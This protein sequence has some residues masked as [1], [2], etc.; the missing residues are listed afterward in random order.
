MTKNSKIRSLLGASVLAVS[1]A[2][3]APANAGVIQLGFIIDSSG[4]IGSTDF[5]VITSG[6]SSA[7]NN[8]IPVG[9]TDTYEVSVVRF[10]STA[11]AVISNVLVTDATARSNLATDIANIAY[12]GGGTNFAAAFSAMEGVLNNTIGDA[13]NIASYVNFSTDGQASLATTEFNSLIGI[14]VDNVS[15]EGIGGNIDVT[16]LTTNYCYPGPCDTTSPY[17]FPTQGFYIG[18]ADAQGYASAIGTKIGIVTGVTV[19]EPATI[20]M[21]GL[22][23]A[24]FAGLRR[25]KN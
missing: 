10:A 19:P 3:V 25:R 21:L 17:N 6:L 4:S 7:V 9:G 14:G 1:A 22:G 15:I 16:E 23:L 24:G 13:D 20:A 2:V 12:S 5:G 11:T 8:F 18:V